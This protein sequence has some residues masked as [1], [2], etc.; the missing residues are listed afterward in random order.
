MS[1]QLIAT[2]GG[3]EGGLSELVTN[4]LADTSRLGDADKA[5]PNRF[6]NVNAGAFRGSGA[7]GVACGGFHQSNNTSSPPARSSTELSY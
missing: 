2:N 1:N 6:M 7:R 4:T 3:G 5:A